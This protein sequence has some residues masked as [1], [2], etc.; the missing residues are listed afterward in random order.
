MTYFCLPQFA[1]ST[2]KTDTVWRALSDKA[3]ARNKELLALELLWE[4]SLEV[5]DVSVCW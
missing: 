5:T 2:I 3:V 1:R 4:G